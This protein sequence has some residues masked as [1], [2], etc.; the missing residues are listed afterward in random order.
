M[1]SSDQGEAS[2]PL[3]R[4]EKGRLL[5][6]QRSLNPSGRPKTK[7]FTAALMRKLEREGEEGLDRFMNTLWAQVLEG[8]KAAAAMAKQLWDRL[9]G[10]VVQQLE[11]THDMR[12]YVAIE[13]EDG[14]DTTPPPMPEDIL[15]LN[16]DD[17]EEGDDDEDDA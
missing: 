15:G 11:A 17:E 4:D 1:S 2:A 10:P 13:G 12:T 6:G 8:D 5:P 9:E 3:L 14:D 16:E 7:A